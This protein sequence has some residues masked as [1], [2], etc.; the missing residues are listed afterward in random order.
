MPRGKL[1]G[2]SSGINYM[3]YVRG[4]TADT[5]MWA[6]LAGDDGWKAQTMMNYM[7]KQQRLESLDPAIVDRTTMPFLG[8]NHGTSGPVRT[9][10]NDVPPMPIESAIIKACDEVLGFDKKPLDPWS[11][12]HIGFFNTLGSVVRSGPR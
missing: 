6:E 2:G 4:S 11:G 1:L 12:D 7:R 10:F 3:M 8:E 9:S 5:N